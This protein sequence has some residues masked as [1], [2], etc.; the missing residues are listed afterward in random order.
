M[1]FPKRFFFKSYEEKYDIIRILNVYRNT[2]LVHISKFF[3][4]ALWDYV[5][6]KDRINETRSTNISNISM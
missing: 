6:N 4:V 1:I 3:Y 2:D 5:L